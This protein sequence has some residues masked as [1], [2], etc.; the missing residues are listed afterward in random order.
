MYLGVKWIISE[1]KCVGKNNN[2]CFYSFCGCYVIKWSQAIG[3]KGLSKENESAGKYFL[4][5][6]SYY[7]LMKD[8]VDNFS[9]ITCT[10]E[11]GTLGSEPFIKKV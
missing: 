2:T 4:G 1:K 11:L 9:V 7:I 3:G 5:R 6:D 8:F 10:S